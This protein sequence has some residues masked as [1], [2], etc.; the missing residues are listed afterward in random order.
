[1]PDGQIMTSELAT[2]IAV[3]GLLVTL[4][5]SL[6]VATRAAKKLLHEL[7]TAGKKGDIFYRYK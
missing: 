7:G 3:V 1:M 4:L 5:R 6:I 2:L